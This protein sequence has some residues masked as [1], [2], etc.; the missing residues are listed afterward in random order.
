MTNSS[1][2]AGIRAIGEVTQTL[3]ALAAR[4]RKRPE[5]VRVDRVCDP[6]ISSMGASVEWFVDAELISGEALSWHLVLYWSDDE[7]IIESGV[8]RM[9]AQGSDP[10][11]EL[12]SRF[13]LDEDLAQELASATR[14]L[15]ATESRIKFIADSTG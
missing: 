2:L 6:R 1:Y 9:G 14:T 11:V 7:W 5:V 12:A 13:A 8:R 3:D 4:L 10:E 15:T